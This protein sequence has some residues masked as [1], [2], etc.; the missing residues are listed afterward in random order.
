[1]DLLVGYGSGSDEEQEQEQDLAEVGAF[2]SSEKIANP[3]IV[4]T[5]T[6]PSASRHIYVIIFA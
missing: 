1:M 6:Q 3:E 5:S 4:M 2:P